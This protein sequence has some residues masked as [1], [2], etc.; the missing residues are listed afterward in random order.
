MRVS[1]LLDAAV[2]LLL[3]SAC[4]GCRRPGLG[5]CRECVRV[6][7]AP[8][9]RLERGPD[10]PLTAANPYRP[11]LEHIVPAF[12]DDGAFHLA[13]F[14]GRRLA[15]AVQ[16]LAPPEGTVL[17]PVPSLPSAVRRRGF[18][19]TDALAAVAARTLGLT[20]RRWLRRGRGGADQSLL[21]RVQRRANLAGAMRAVSGARRT[22]VIVDDL[23]TTGATLREAH[24]ALTEA[25]TQVWG[26]AVIGDVDDHDAF[27]LV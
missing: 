20:H 14:L 3:G 15:C 21:G 17:V 25:G 27:P 13:G 26:G 19:H 9:F 7:S 4:P 2:D 5:I 23:A 8:A 10:L 1:D 16:A 24:R 18:D 22:V 11:L 6:L 12:K